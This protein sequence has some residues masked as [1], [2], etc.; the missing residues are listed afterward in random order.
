[1]VSEVGDLI[2]PFIAEA[3]ERLW[4]STSAG[5]VEYDGFQWKLHDSDYWIDWVVSTSDGQLWTYL[6]KADC[7]KTI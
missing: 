4:V 1:M 6:W 5:I 2:H 7:K 3:R